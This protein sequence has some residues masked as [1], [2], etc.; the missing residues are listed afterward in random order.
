MEDALDYDEDASP[1]HPLTVEAAEQ[2]TRAMRSLAR[3]RRQMAEVRDV[4][5]AEID[6]VTSW[7][8]GRL[9]TLA[10][11]EAWYMEG[12]ES[13]TRMLWRESKTQTQSLPT[14]T[15]RLRP[16][17]LVVE[18]SAPESLARVAP[19]LT[20]QKVEVDKAE[21]KAR[22]RPGAEL[23]V[24]EEDASG[25]LAAHAAVTIAD[26]VDAETGEPVPAGYVMPGI[27][28]LVDSRM[29]FSAKEADGE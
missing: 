21:V 17:P 8:D 26:A 24:I 16:A 25:K 12:L 23:R 6:R 15:L 9:N 10:A 27:E 20:R 13:Y 1:N 4:A 22:L 28:F 7:R 11:R 29:R 18:A 19:F 2:A 5:K 14:G 3:I